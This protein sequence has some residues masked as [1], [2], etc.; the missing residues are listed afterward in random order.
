MLGEIK[1]LEGV[2]SPSSKPNV[3]QLIR[4]TVKLKYIN[5]LDGK[6]F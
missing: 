4:I 1:K 2:E 6:E 3:I 5:F